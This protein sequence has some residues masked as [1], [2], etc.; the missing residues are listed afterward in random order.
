MMN[1]TRSS[2]PVGGRPQ[3]IIISH[4]HMSRSRDGTVWCYIVAGPRTNQPSLEGRKNQAGE[5][6]NGLL[7]KMH[8]PGLSRSL[9]CGS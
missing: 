2:C 5:Y 6:D 4:N 9:P 7:T 3:V 1:I 8:L